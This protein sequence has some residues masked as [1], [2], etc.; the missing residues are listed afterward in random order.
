MRTLLILFGI[1]IFAS[2]CE[3][4]VA[5]DITAETPVLILPA[6]NDTVNQSSVH[7]KWEELEG[8]SK[9]HLEVVSPSFAAIS[10]FVLDSVVTGTDFYFDLDSN[11]YEIRL[12]AQNGGYD[13]QV[14]APVKFWV[15]VQSSGG[16]TSDVI[17]DSPIDGIYM[18]ASFDGFFDW[19]PASGATNQEFSLREGSSFISGSFVDGQNN[20]SL[21]GYTTT[22]TLAE[23][24]YFWG[25]K[26][27]FGTTEAPY[28]IGHFFIDEFDP[29]EAALSSPA[30]A[31]FE[32][33]GDILFTW[34]N[35]T[36]PGTINSPVNSTLEITTDSSFNTSDTTI[37]VIGSSASANLTPDIYYWRVT[38]MDEAGNAAGASAIYQVTV[39]P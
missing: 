27:Y 3:K 8:A 15:G 4:I 9:Y 29:N 26:A 21:P 6:A 25:V 30:D 31:S 24:E 23:G 32:P 18:N 19:T 5:E 7:F 28:E 34:V 37:T 13:S 10:E 12:T 2:S 39:T 16:G 1:A 36:D 38:N 35:G 33:T 20:I 14:S 11:E 17:L 22:A